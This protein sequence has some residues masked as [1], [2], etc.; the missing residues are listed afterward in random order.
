MN[1]AVTKSNEITGKKVK[2]FTKSEW[3]HRIRI[4]I[5][6]G[7]TGYGG[8]EKLYNRQRGKRV[9]TKLPELIN[10]DPISMM[11]QTRFEDY[12]KFFLFAFKGND[13][14][15][16]WNQIMGLVDGFCDAA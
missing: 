5:A 7:P 9:H 15:D 16:P 14:D 10:R 12:R 11:H 13:P 4:I 2:A 3:W 8:F 6:A 1:A